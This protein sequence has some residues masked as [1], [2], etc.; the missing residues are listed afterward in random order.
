MVVSAGS[1]HAR[2]GCETS[3]LSRPMHLGGKQ[4]DLSGECPT[5]PAAATEALSV[6][7]QQMEMH[8]HVNS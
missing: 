4:G 1:A 6:S 8:K 3:A 5:V 2:H 7:F